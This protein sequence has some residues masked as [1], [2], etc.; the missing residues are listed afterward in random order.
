MDIANVAAGRLYVLVNKFDQ[1][2]RNSDSEEEIKIFVAN[3]LMEGNISKDV[4][5][6]VSSKLGYS[7]NRA[8]RELFLHQMLP[9][10]QTHPWVMDFGKEAFGSRWERQIS[11]SDKALE[12]AD[13]LWEDSKFHAPL[14]SVIKSA[15]AQAA[16]FA[17][18]SAS[19]KLVDIS[20]K[21][22][23]FLNLRETALSKNT[24]ELK[25]QIKA[26]QNDVDRVNAIEMA[27]TKSSEKMLAGLE[28]EG[29]RIFP[30]YEA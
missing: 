27:A 29:R 2:D 5:F 10:H 6:P 7:A 26:L 1:R 19:S 12:H 8:K 17:V 18:D 20:E 14:E 15:H 24:Q 23:N 9:D 28:T 16:L 3:G 22:G 25:E 21:L 4:V 30:D 11:D 13:Y